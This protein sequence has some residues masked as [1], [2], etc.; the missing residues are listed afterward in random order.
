MAGPYTPR[1]ALMSGGTSTGPSNR[2][3]RC[4]P[5]PWRGLTPARPARTRLP[6]PG[7][8]LDAPVPPTSWA[9]DSILVAAPFRSDFA[10]GVAL[11]RRTRRGLTPAWP[12]GARPAEPA[13]QADPGARGALGPR[14]FLGRP[15]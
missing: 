6:G 4:P 7:H 13:R 10:R 11:P 3:P 2:A 15:P 1:P 8:D 9:S 5:Q 12:A 14:G